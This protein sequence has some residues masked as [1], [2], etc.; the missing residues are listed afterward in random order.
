MIDLAI[1]LMY[2]A[3]IFR[4]AL[5]LAVLPLAPSLLLPDSFFDYGIAPITFAAL[6]ILYAASA[7]LASLSRQLTAAL[8]LLCMA[9]Y[10]LIFSF[11][12]WINSDVET[13]IYIHHEIIVV[14]LH[15]FIVLSFS[16]RF[17]RLVDWLLR[18]RH[19][20]NLR[21]SSVQARLASYKGRD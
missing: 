17:K 18:Y 11:D 6:S 19:R 13:W 15:I 12:S 16:G 10:L 3:V 1:A 21:N 8:A 4:P 5:L 7:V 2:L 14:S 20:D 9:V